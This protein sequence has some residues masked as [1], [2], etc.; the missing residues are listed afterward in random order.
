[1]VRTAPNKRK[2]GGYHPE[3]EFGDGLSYS[4]F[5]IT[6]FKLSSDTL[7]GNDKI[8]ASFSVKN[9]GN[10][11]GTKNIDVFVSDHYASLAPDVR[12][13]KAFSSVFL[14]PG[15][16]KQV[17]VELDKENLFF[18]NKKGKKLLE[19]GDFSISVDNETKSFYYL[20]K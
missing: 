20:S 9:S 12:N 16:Q 1:M 8:I 19:N 17:N 5:D 14:K 15:E 2:Y 18:Y 7:V 4:N 3:F 11:N 13:L 10:F 6:D